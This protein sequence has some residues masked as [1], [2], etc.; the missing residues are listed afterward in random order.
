VRYDASKQFAPDI[1]MTDYL[2]REAS[3]AIEAN[4]NRPFFMYLA[5]NAPHTPL[6]ALKSD[7]D[8]LAGIKDH[9]HDIDE[10]EQASKNAKSDDVKN[11]AQSTLPTL[12][13]HLDAAEKL[14][15]K[16]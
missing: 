4:K 11:F 1:Y 2:G 5:F 16:G 12:K 8:A 3:K 15:A 9:R 14:P 10:F 6:Q 13:K 7:Y